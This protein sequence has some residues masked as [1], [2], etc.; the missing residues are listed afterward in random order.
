[1]AIVSENRRLLI[2][3]SENR[4]MRSGVL[5]TEYVVKFTNQVLQ[6][7]ACLT[8]DMV[9]MNLGFPARENTKEFRLSIAQLKKYGLH[10]GKDGRLVNVQMNTRDLAFRSHCEQSDLFGGY[11]FR[12]N[13]IRT[14]EDKSFEIANLNWCFDCQEETRLTG[15]DWSVLHKIIK[16][17]KRETG[18]IWAIPS[19]IIRCS[20]CAAIYRRDVKREELDTDET[21]FLDSFILE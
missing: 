14:V 15:N 5:K 2:S 10:T 11:W 21:F 12:R 20:D 6:K 1:M 17:L 8:G 9:M 18:K 7:V 3:I 19:S 13:M 16:R 4:Y